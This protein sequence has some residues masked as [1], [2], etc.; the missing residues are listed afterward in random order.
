[1]P[2]YFYWG[3]DD[4]AMNQEINA[5]KDKILDPHW[6]QFNY[7]KLSGNK[8]DSL[9]E[10]FLQIMTPVFGMGERLVW[11]EETTIA[12]S[13]PDDLFTELK[14]TI[15]QI[16][17]T[18]HLLLTSSKKPDSRLKSTK[19]LQKYAEIKEFSL[20]SSWETEAILKKVVETAKNQGVNLTKEARELL[21]K[22]VGN[23][24]RLLWNELEKLS[25]YQDNKNIPIDVD[26]VKELVNI[27]N[28]NS[29]ELAT[30]I[31]QGNMDLALG[32]VNNLIHINEPALRIVATLVGQFRTWT[33]VKLMLEEKDKQDKEIAE[34]AD[35]GNP[36]RLYFLRKELQNV[37]SQQLLKA[38]PLLFE[39]ELSLKR[40]ANPLMIL[41][42]KVI[43]LAS[44]FC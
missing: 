15:P 24:S 28:Q 39:L 4:F 2:V 41:E 36:K 43:E 37:S 12:Q 6:I 34:F 5:L 42:T 9:D 22:S 33:M 7:D 31:L 17:Q 25:L 13:C 20:I 35:L 23:N 32:L 8:S 14:R 18:S 30:A 26:T 40:G 19:L 11:V 16:P 21:A 3:E 38:L 1:M 29:L 27:S 44:I 10:V